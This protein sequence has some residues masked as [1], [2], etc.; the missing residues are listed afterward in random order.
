LTH[1]VSTFHWYYF[2][3]ALPLLFSLHKC[4]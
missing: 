2:R 4:V 3:G 1:F